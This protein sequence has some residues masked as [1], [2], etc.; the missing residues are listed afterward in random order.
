[1]CLLAPCVSPGATA[2]RVAWR[3]V[4]FMTGR[5][6]GRQVSGR[7]FAGGTFPK[8]LV[9]VRRRPLAV[10]R[11]SRSAPAAC[12]ERPRPESTISVSCQLPPDEGRS[13]CTAILACRRRL[14]RA[15]RPHRLRGLRSTRPC[16]PRDSRRRRRGEA[17]VW[18][19]DGDGP[20]A[21]LAEAAAMGSLGAQVTSGRHEESGT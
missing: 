10:P 2:M 17:Q 4:Y 9:T 16:R 15:A 5:A 1:M 18:A 13:A 8:D 14:A 19:V 3:D 6:A 21:E 20:D 12:F 11:P 7:V